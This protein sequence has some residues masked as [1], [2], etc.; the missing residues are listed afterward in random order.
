V[1][2]FLVGPL[3]AGADDGVIWWEGESPTE[4]N[5]P[6]QTWFSRDAIAGRTELLSGGAWL[7]SDGARGEAEM[8]ARYEVEVGAAGRYHFWVR[9]FWKHGPFEWRFDEGA[10]TLCGKDV[11]LADRVELGKHVEANWVKLG[12]VELAAGRRKF[13]LRLTAK[14]GQGTTSGFDAFVLSRGTFLPSGA[15]KPGQ[16]SGVA[17]A[18]WFA[19]E[20]GVDGFDAGALLDLRTLN[21]KEAGQSGFMRREGERLVLGDGRP[22]RLWGINVSRENLGVDGS[23]TEYLAR[24]LAKLGYNAVRYHGA[25][26]DDGAADPLAI[27]AGAMA[28]LHRGVAAFKRQGIYTTISFYFPLWVTVR[29]PHGIAGFEGT[30]DKRPMG[31]IFFDE[32]MQ[33]IHRDWLK[34][35]L[36][37]PDGATGRR[38]ADEPAVAMVE[39]VNEDS[40]LFWTLNRKSIP[41]AQWAGLER[42]FAQWLI[43]RHGSIEAAVKAW[44]GALG[45]GDDAAGGAGGAGGRMEVMEPWHMTAAG[46]KGRGEAHRRRMSDQVRFLAELQRDFYQRTAEY[47]KR[48]L[49]Y[50]GLVVASNWTT[51]DPAVLDAAERWSYA[52]GDVM[53]RHAYFG[54]KHEGP[55]AGYSVRV[56]HGYE[57]RPLTKHPAQTPVQTV[58]VAGYPQII[59]EMGWTNPNRFRADATLI[60]GAYGALQGIDGMF[61]FAVGSPHLM[62]RSLGKFAMTTPMM[63]GSSP[64]AAVMYR[65]GDVA[66][67]AVVSHE[68]MSVEDVFAL[69]GGAAAGEALDALRKADVPGGEGGEPGDAEERELAFFA[70]KVQR[71][72]DGAKA[73][74]VDAGALVRMDRQVVIASTKELLWDYGRGVVTVNTAR[75]QGVAGFIGGMQIRLG[76]VTVASGNEYGSVMVVSMDDKPVRESGRLLVQAVTEERLHGFKV[77]QGKIVD[78]GKWPFVLRRIDGAVTLRRSGL[79]AG[80]VKV[81]AL[82]GNGR[83][84]G[85]VA[86]QVTGEGVSFQLRGDAMHHV[87]TVR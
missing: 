28:D 14:Q 80:R 29:E 10:W 26:F 58:G 69:W 6:K 82:D 48:D 16:K 30:A 2:F 17:E 42:R 84:M 83:A 86:A 72:V 35:I 71:S 18:G 39:L 23:T 85:E 5:F 64:A 62:D 44:G 8:F 12:E 41:P 73:E 61:Q 21:E 59:S 34:A 46:M 57:D 81:V 24:R 33:A 7:T 56:G 68:A 51:A 36:T 4:T 25:M 50:G 77:E 3:G 20:P 19:Y 9:K 63:I 31:L 37:T 32:R 60:S 52:A 27:N 75:S 55:G 38:L 74:V 11:A 78:L 13:E 22:V 53:D 47:V 79:E 43:A 49:G 76:D 70:G 45:K 65:R 87:V 67:G 54:G 40:L 15:T 66:E 1:F